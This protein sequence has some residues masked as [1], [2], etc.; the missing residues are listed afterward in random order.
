M[1]QIGPGGNRTH[2]GAAPRT[3]QKELV[4]TLRQNCKKQTC[5]FSKANGHRGY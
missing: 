4:L 5:V 2:G 3:S 1:F